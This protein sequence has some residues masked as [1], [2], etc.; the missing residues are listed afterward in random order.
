MNTISQYI[1]LDGIEVQVDRKKVKHLRL[2]VSPPDGKVRMSVPVHVSEQMAR[3]FLLSRIDWVKTKQAEFNSIVD[4]AKKEFITG[5]IHYFLGKPY[6]MVA[7]ERK[8]RQEI[9]KL[10]SELILYIKP[11]AATLVRNKIFDYWYR[12]ELKSLI[13]ELLEKWQPIV[14]KD[15]MEW[16]VKKMKS[17]W[18]SCNIN[19]K[20]IWLNLELIKKPLVCIEYVLVHELVH[21]LERH[22]NQQFKEHM[23]HFMPDWQSYKR[24]LN[25]T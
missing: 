1:M 19:K 23:G 24:V 15:V 16:N 17:R 22:H 13:P 18:G 3:M 5:E 8:G 11:G 14:G 10:D 20:R 12:A 21:L 4:I 25:Y 7:I 6:R 9:V 2:V